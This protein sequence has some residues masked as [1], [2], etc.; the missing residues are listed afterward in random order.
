M[1]ISFPAILLVKKLFIAQ[2]MKNA[3]VE[4]V[5]WAF[6]IAIFSNMA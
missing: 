4:K 5:H 3:P 6:Y 1:F 2:W